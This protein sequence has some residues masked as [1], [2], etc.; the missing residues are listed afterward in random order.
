MDEEDTMKGQILQS[1]SFQGEVPGREVGAEGKEE[2]VRN[3][4]R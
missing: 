1:G 2:R 4:R 3:L